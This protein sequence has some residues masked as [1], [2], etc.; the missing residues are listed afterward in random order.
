MAELQAVATAPGFVYR[1]GGL[2]FPGLGLWM[3]PSKPVRTGE[4][5]VVT[6]A[7]AD[8]TARHGAVL[9]TE[10]TRRLMRARVPG[11]R[12]EHVL[13]YSRVLR[14]GD[15]GEPAARAP[16]TLSFHPAG[17]ILGS[18][19]ARVEHEGDSVLYTGDFKLRPGLSSERCEPVAARTLVM[20]TTYGRPR[21]RFPPTAAVL[22]DIVRFCTTTLEQ[23]ATPVLLAY[24]L[25]K[26]QEVL[27]ALCDPVLPIQL[28]PKAAEMTRIYADLGHRFPAWTPLDPETVRG[29]VVITP[30]LRPLLAE[31]GRTG[32][33]RIAS[34]SG[35]ALDSRRASD[36]SGGQA[37]RRFPLSDHADFED[38]LEFVRQVNPQRVFTL[39]GFAADF[40]RVLRRQGVEARALSEDDRQLDLAL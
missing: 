25:G 11:R 14:S 24:S 10:P 28:H 31:P 35:W 5:S 36:P 6:H 23:G 30:T 12:I 9:L 18:A 16:F 27:S 7:H 20:E 21:Y 29:H 39:H 33:L 22:E 1:N 26:T 40:A 17:H 38:L 19:M 37:H 13:D 8:H 32:P 4:W 3:D 2:H 34:L 15:L